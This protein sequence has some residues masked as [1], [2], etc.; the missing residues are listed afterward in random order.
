MT[1]RRWALRAGLLG[2]GLAVGVGGGATVAAWTSK[3]D[4][5]A[6]TVQAIADWVAPPITDTRLVKTEGGTPGFVRPGGGYHVCTTVGAD[7]GNPASGFASLATDLTTLGG[8]LLTATLAPLAG[9][10]CPSTSTRDTGLQTLALTAAAGTRAIA[11]TSRDV[12]GNKVTASANVVVDATAPTATAFATAN[13]PGGT[14]GRID[15]VD[16]ISFRFSEPIEPESVIPGWDGTS[17][18]PMGVRF[19]DAGGPTK[20]PNPD[21]FQ[22]GRVTSTGTVALPITPAAV[23][24]ARNYLSASVDFTSASISRNAAGDVY[25]VVLGTTAATVFV[26]NTA[27]AAVSWSPGTALRDRAW[28][29]ASTTAAPDAAS[30]DF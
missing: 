21:T 8:T 25:T 24:L 22:L 2:A 11:V 1:A 19:V 5:P 28:N 26:T 15:G 18:A 12:A 23:S 30:P 10:P 6:G 14:V 29:S 7:S 13:G 27:S 3:V 20:N 9:S 16:S 4:T 17:A